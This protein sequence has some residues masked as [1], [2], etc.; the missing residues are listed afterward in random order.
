MVCIV[1][2]CVFMCAAKC[3]QSNAKRKASS[4]RRSFKRCT[5]NS[6]SISVR[7]LH[8]QLGCFRIPSS[9]FQYTWNGI[10]LLSSLFWQIFCLHLGKPSSSELVVFWFNYCEIS[11]IMHIITR[12]NRERGE[13]GAFFPIKRFLICHLVSMVALVMVI[14]YN[15]SIEVSIEHLIWSHFPICSN[16]YVY[17]CSSLISITTNKY[18]F[19]QRAHNTISC[20]NF[21]M[22]NGT[23]TKHNILA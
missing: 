12:F 11:V 9:S 16:L 21:R 5:N 18:P 1:C 17:D 10:S 22:I 14:Y 3:M 2:V 20:S 6:I 15:C 4:T 7:S 8:I 19:R 13:Q 23:H